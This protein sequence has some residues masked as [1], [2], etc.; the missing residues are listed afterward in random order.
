M[1]TLID[2]VPSQPVREAAARAARAA[3]KE[4]AI[5]SLDAVQIARN[6]A[7]HRRANK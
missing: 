1:R 7:K 3:T 5:R 6:R 2:L 4:N